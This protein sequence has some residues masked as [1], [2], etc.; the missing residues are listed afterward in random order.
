MLGPHNC[1]I[2]DPRIKRDLIN[3]AVDEGLIE[4]YTVGNVNDRT[5]PVT[6]CRLDRH[7][8]VVQEYLRDAEGEAGEGESDE[9]E[10]EAGANEGA[11]DAG[12]LEMDESSA[13]PVRS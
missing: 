10:A 8:D 9:G 11:G 4:M 6:A 7:S 1:G 3:E 12:E 5:D 13:E 2:Q